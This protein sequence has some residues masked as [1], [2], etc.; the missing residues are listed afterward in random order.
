MTRCESPSDWDRFIGTLEPRSGEKILDIGA[1]RG[2][3]ANRVLGASEGAEVYAVEPGE[4]KVASMKREFPAIKSSVAGAEHLPYPDS[5]FDRAYTTMALHHFSD[6]DLAL[7]EVARVLKPGGSF[8]ILEVEPGS[9]LGRMFRFFGRLMGERM[10]IM[11]EEQLL[12]KLGTSEG[13]RLDNSS[14]AGSRYLVRLVR[15]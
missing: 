9:G 4:K 2:T 10:N 13:L 14:R 3:V 15:T 7:R 1:G 8:V 11:T 5:Y 12:A 6:L